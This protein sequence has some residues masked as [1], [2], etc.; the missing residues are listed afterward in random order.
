MP[1]TSQ[2]LSA[3]VSCLLAHEQAHLADREP[4]TPGSTG[5]SQPPLN[6]GIDGITSELNAH[7]VEWDCLQSK[8][9]GCVSHGCQVDIH[10]RLN[11]VFSALA[12]YSQGGP[13]EGLPQTPYPNPVAGTIIT[14]P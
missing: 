10:N 6:A 11:I 5:W 1:T 9:S 4:C 12:Y 8:L 3:S 14:Y 7:K 13:H 2:G